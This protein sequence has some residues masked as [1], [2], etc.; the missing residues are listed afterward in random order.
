MGATLQPI[1]EPTF[2]RWVGHPLVARAIN[3]AGDGAEALDILEVM[4]EMMG[5]LEKRFPGVPFETILATPA[6]AEARKRARQIM[7]HEDVD[8]ADHALLVGGVRPAGRQQATLG[9]REYEMARA[10]RGW[11]WIRAELGCNESWARQIAQLANPL[12]PAE[13]Q[14]V[15]AVNAGDSF[16]G[17]CRRL[18]VSQSTGLR[19]SR[20]RRYCR[21]LEAQS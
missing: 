11:R 12:S 9:D 16:N 13:Q 15:D 21:W 7:M 10:G 14:V 1:D 8:P 3:E 18:G 2:E 19:A 6:S 17:A 4:S 20:K 5:V